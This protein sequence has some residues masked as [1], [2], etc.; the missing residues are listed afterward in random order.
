MNARTLATL[1]LALCAACSSEESPT[2]AVA[3]Q[4]LVFPFMQD[5]TAT[6][7][8]S[9]EGEHFHFNTPASGK[10][11]GPEASTSASGGVGE[12][13]APNTGTRF[14]ATFRSDRTTSE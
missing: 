5:N 9:M 11:W 13:V 8:V 12:R 14:S 2:L 10:S 1:G 7:L 6:G 3:E 4:A